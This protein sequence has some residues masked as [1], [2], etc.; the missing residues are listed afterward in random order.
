M[1]SPSQA[2]KKR[3]CKLGR[4]FYILAVN[5]YKRKRAATRKKQHST[6]GIIWMTHALIVNHCSST[7]ICYHSVAYIP[8]SRQSSYK[9]M[10]HNKIS[11][12]CVC[13]VSLPPTSTSYYTSFRLARMSILHAIFCIKARPPIYKNIHRNIMIQ[14]WLRHH[15][16]KYTLAAFPSHLFLRFVSWN[17]DAFMSIRR[18]ISQLSLKLS[19][20]SNVLCG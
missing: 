4:R 5:V 13:K 10:P 19:F 7:S 3:T 2:P 14:H 15:T 11:R 16:Y 9:I 8:L 20:T 12:F 6:Q 18:L 1:L 17:S